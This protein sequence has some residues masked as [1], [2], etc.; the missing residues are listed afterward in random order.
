MDLTPTRKGQAADLHRRAAGR[1][2][3]GPRPEA[4]LPRGGGLHHRRH[5]GGRPRRQDRGRADELRGHPAGPRRRDGGVPELI[6]EV[7][8]EATFPDGTKLVTVHKPIAAGARGAGAGRDRARPRRRHR[9]QRR[10]RRSIESSVANTGDR[11]IQVG[12][13][14]HFFETNPALVFDRGRTRGHAPGHPRRHGGA[15]RARPD[16]RGGAGRPTPASGWST[17]SGAR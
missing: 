17:A 11:P 10:A 4:E 3:Q 13:H 9:H 15:L 12:S 14:Y 7:Q 2:A 6:P 16:A 1:A 5:P 8:V